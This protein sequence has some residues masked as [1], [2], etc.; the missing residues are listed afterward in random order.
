[1]TKNSILEQDKFW[2]VLKY[3]TEISGPKALKKIC[4]DTNL[5]KWELHP[6]LNFLEEINYS[7]SI[8]NEGDE[9]IFTPPVDKPHFTLEFSLLEW[10]QF[11]A[12]F[13]KIAECVGSPYHAG[14]K[15]KLLA[16]EEKHKQSDIFS[17]VLTLEHVLMEQ[18][19]TLID[20]ANNPSKEILIFLEESIVEK[21]VVHLK[22]DSNSLK[23]LPRKIV[24]FDGR[25]NL[26]A[27]DTMDKSLLNIVINNISQVY[28]ESE[29]YEKEYS[30]IQIDDFVSSLRSMTDTDVRLVLK[31]YS[32]DRFRLNF[33][34]TFFD[35][36]CLFTNPDGDFIWAATLEPSDEIFEWLCEL[37]SAVEILDP[38]NFKLDF[39]KYCEHKLKKLA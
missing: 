26:V 35:N 36:P 31:I 18:K 14:F 34:S 20:E 2:K 6:F 24:F 4:E 5:Q 3:L 13:P 21:K 30:R 1:M 17:P 23:V 28:E 38:T 16:E 19:P 27:E 10:V 11:Q 15:E 33:N 9:K 32:Q 8:S 25:L 7:F 37:G 22:T 39:I 29:P 12:H